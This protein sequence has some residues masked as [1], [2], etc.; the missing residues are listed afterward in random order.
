MKIEAVL[1]SLESIPEELRDNYVESDDGKYRLAALSGF[2]PEEKIAGLKSAVE[3]ERELGQI[4][5]QERAQLREK[6]EK[7]GDIDPDK[8]HELLEA[9]EKAEQERL[10]KRGEWEKLRDQMKTAHETEIETLRT[11]NE[12]LISKFERM[13]IERD[14]RTAL[15]EFKGNPRL[16]LPHIEKNVKMIR[17]EDTGEFSLRVLDDAGNPRIDATGSFLSVSDL[18]SEMR[19]TEDF[20]SAFKG[21]SMTG[22]GTPPAGETGS[23]GAT[24]G[25]TPD[26]VSGLR[27]STMSKRE[28]IDIIRKHGNDVF[29]SIPE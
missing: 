13:F 9:Q 16:L 20:G 3:K 8:Y 29:L 18:V 7:F 11:S 6:M 25:G 23:E 19:Q 10:E 24:A 5:R 15:D 28:K 4:A 14:A 1:D 26:D 12:K 21:S 17:D 22:G 27:R 2:V